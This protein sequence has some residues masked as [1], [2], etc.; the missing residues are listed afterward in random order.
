MLHLLKIEWLKV[1]NYRTFWVLFILYLVS[2][3]GANY[4]VYD[5]LQEELLDTMKKK[6]EDIFIKMMIG[7]P[8]YSFP[9]NW[10][11]TSY[12]SSFLFILL[13]FLTII[14]LTNEFNFKTHRQNLIDGLTRNKFIFSKILV[15]IT[16][17]AISTV[18][19][20]ITAFAFGFTGN[21]PFGGEYLKYISISFIQCLN[22]C[23][24]ALLLSVL[25]KRS[26][27]AIGVYFVYVVIVEFILFHV[28]NKFLD[29]T[30]FYLPVESADTLIP[31][32][33]AKH[34]QARFVTRPDLS[35]ILIAC[36]TY[37]ALYVLITFQ[38][39]KRKNL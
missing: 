6:P 1:K 31:F 16:L 15:V 33:I 4:L 12:V 18:V 37:I 39:F 35:Y 5:R 26:G 19:I 28:F 24:L 17:A 38:R 34:I 36:F 32:P 7:E 21:N 30:G 29:N 20:G 9:L 3:V 23:L 10:A 2:I 8:P 27:I 13:G 11:M 14:L 22:Y 25:F